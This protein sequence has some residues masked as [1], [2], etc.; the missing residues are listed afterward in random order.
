MEDISE[1]MRNLLSIADDYLVENDIF[2][3]PMSWRSS[4]VK[5]I[6]IR[7]TDRLHKLVTCKYANTQTLDFYCDSVNTPLTKAVSSGQYQ[8]AKILL[9]NGSSV[10]FPNK[11]DETALM[12]AA[13][14]G[15]KH[16]CSILVHYGANPNARNRYGGT[17]MN[18]A[19][20]NG[21]PNVA[22]FLL[23]HGAT[24]N[25]SIIECAMLGSQTR[26]LKLLL[27]YRL[28]PNIRFPLETVLDF[29]IDK[30]SECCAVT[31][32]EQGYYPKKGTKHNLYRSFFYK[33]AKNGLVKL[34]SVLVELNP[35]F[36]QEDWLIRKVYFRALEPHQNYMSWLNEYR[37][38]VPSLSNLCKSAILAQLSAHDEYYTVNVN[39]LPLPKYLKSYLLATESEYKHTLN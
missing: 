21:K 10:D 22:M 4:V 23:E 33:S 7:D 24:L 11:D 37:K 39:V 3:W 5:A 17:A 2:L 29:A 18:K 19:A 12:I 16:T 38:Q 9:Q 6:S 8:A 1:D 13:R 27:E 34:M 20:R 26:I 14:D 25:Y 28:C 36:L 35:Q 32:L 31:T 30:H 15:C